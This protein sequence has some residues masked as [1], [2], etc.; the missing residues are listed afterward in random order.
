M[1]LQSLVESAARAFGLPAE[2]LAPEGSAANDLPLGDWCVEDWP[3]VDPHAI[4]RV[5]EAQVLAPEVRGRKR[6]GAFYTPSEVAR[7]LARQTLEV[8]WTPD[9][10]P[11]EDGNIRH[12][13]MR[14]VPVTSSVPVVL[15]PACGC[16][17]LLIEALRALC[18][19]WG[20]PVVGA[21]AVLR[22]CD[23]EAGAV[24]LAR[25]ALV[26]AA[27][28][29]GARG[30]D[31]LAIARALAGNLIVHDSLLAG[32]PE[33]AGCLLMNPPYV[34]AAW[35]SEH[36]AAI[37][38]AF[39]TADGAFDLHVPFIELAV[40]SVHAG[41]VFGVLTSDKFLVADYGREL[42][43]MMARETTLIRVIDLADAT[44][45]RPEASVSQAITIGV[46]QPPP[47]DHG[48]E[49]LHPATMD[50]LAA[51]RTAV[52]RKLQDELLGSR[53]PALRATPNEQRV[54]AKMTAGGTVRLD[55]IALVRGGVRGFDYH[56]CCRELCE[57][58]GDR[59]EMTVLC[60]GNVRAY[61]APAEEAVRLDGRRWR[62]PCLRARPEAV[63]E[64]LWELFAQ[65]KL[66][67]KGIGRR[68]TAAWVPEPGAL[69]VAVWGIWAD[70]ELLW[71]L[72]G[73]LNSSAAAWL[74]YQQLY[75]ARVPRGS[76]RIPLSWVAAFP[77]PREGLEDVGAVARALVR[78]GDGGRGTEDGRG[79][80]EV[81]LDE[82]VAEVYELDEGEQALMAKAPLREVQW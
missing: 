47:A 72:L 77:V 46:R 32:V 38:R 63:A 28:Q 70:E 82:L 8:W 12:A 14:A 13:R 10:R 19:A 42:R 44:G 45:A 48:A 33:P 76:L 54:L 39:P 6:A 20:L 58:S 11:G 73:L 57:A 22:G 69:L 53:W 79:R 51:G 41:G 16:G 81:E 56:A 55:S 61:R 59:G 7:V 43:A 23:R 24:V 31:L 5:Y 80:L 27:G 49:V 25:V 71:R 9:D 1:T 66:V 37:R 40:R 67:V 18:G 64:H 65:P 3:S 75:T 35:A 60:P 29:L 74:H 26:V 62:R 36:R 21:A 78:L 50:E 30:A 2:V 15:D 4:G 34:R 52:V 17:S 68:P